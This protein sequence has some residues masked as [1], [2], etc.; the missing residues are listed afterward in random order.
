MWQPE[1]MQIWISLNF[2]VTFSVT[3]LRQITL[4]TNARK[5]KLS[6]FDCYSWM[7]S[8]ESRRLAVKKTPFESQT[9]RWWL[10]KT[11]WRHEIHE[12]DIRGS[13]QSWTL[14]QFDPPPHRRVCFYRG[15]CR[16]LNQNLQCAIA[17]ED[18][19]KTKQGQIHVYIATVD[20]YMATIYSTV[21][22]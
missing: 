6:R 7:T 19:R 12:V 5:C 20:G 4:A 13:L 9:N 17:E 18:K 3:L 10:V 11:E 2:I 16:D 21:C 8:L 15:T 14:L 22:S 1:T